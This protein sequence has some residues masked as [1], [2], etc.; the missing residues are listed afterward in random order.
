MRLARLIGP[1]LQALLTENPAELRE[2]LDEIH[3]EDMSD[4]V[5]E[6]DDEKAAAL[7]TE[8]PPDYAAQVFERLDEGR[9]GTLAGLMGAGSVARIATE[10]PADDRTDFFS[11]LP[12]D[13]GEPLLEELEKFAPE[14]AEEVEELQRWPETSAGGLMT[15]EYV[16]VPPDVTLADAIEEVRRHADEAETLE[17]VYV[18]NSAHRLLGY[19]QLKTLLLA[20]PHELVRDVQTTNVI[21][22]PPEL[23]QEEV[24]KVLAKYDL[25][26]LPVVDQKG[27][28][29]GVITSDDILDVITAEQ[30]EDVQK[31]GAI[32]PSHEGYFDSTIGMYIKRRAPWLVILFVGGFFTTTAM[33][34]YDGVLGAI[35][36]LAFYVPLLVSAGGNSGSQSSTLVIRGLAVGDIRTRDWLRVLGREL[37]QGLVLGLMLATLGGV[38]VLLSGDGVQFAAVVALTLTGIVMMGCVVGGMMPILLHRLGIDPATSSNPFIATL[39][40]VLGILIYL[41]LAQLLLGA[42]VQQLL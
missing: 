10:M 21:S 9:Q 17:V 6:L 33:R 30:T 42:A 7:L 22:V 28:M 15:T 35:A 11:I 36:N 38:R 39:V 23:D 32:A 27:E 37:V 5:G 41:S 34:A 29:L 3:P 26:V 19:L 14:A 40:D 13:V 2:L 20:K 1:E 24:A 12:P 4:V 25:G 18:V 8:L 16:S 31:M